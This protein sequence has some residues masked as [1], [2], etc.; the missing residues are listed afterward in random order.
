MFELRE[1]TA[2]KHHL[3]DFLV[4]VCMCVGGREAPGYV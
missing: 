1:F 2:F 3:R 4:Q